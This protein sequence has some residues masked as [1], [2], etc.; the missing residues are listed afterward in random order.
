VARIV[1]AGG[2]GYL[3]RALTRRL[4]TRHDEVVVLTRGASCQNDGWR[5]VRW[6]ARTVG[7]WA[8]ELEGADAIVHLNG[9]SVD[10]RATRRNIEE[11]I[12]S[13][14]DPVR[15]VGGGLAGCA[16]PPP[17]WVQSGSLA[18]FGDTGDEVIDESSIP[19]ASGPPEMVSVCRAWETA[20]AEAVTPV[21]RSILLRMSIAL[22]G[23]D[24]R[25]TLRLAR[26][27]GWGLGGTVGSGKQWV[28][29]IALN[30]LL[31]I[32]VR[33]IDDP[34]MTGLYHATSP[35]PV[36]NAEMMATFRAAMGKRVGLPT[37]AM[38]ARLGAPILG[39]SASL[40]LTGRRCVPTRLL[41]EGFSFRHSEFAETVRAALETSGA[42]RH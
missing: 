6:D 17:V 42:G 11:L 19:T 8:E 3:G 27:V 5:A 33:A 13:R 23:Q 20:Y 15:A 34:S 10:T 31:D 30:D 39:T 18:L 16:S 14:V 24:D 7:D 28:S 35:S 9:R 26:I 4:V 37:P 22:G 29:W 41:S 40:A 32:L 2:T 38:I 12:S 25:A 1:I 21:E 36:T